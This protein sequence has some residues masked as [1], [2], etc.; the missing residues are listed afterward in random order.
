MAANRE[1]ALPFNTRQY[2]HL[3]VT[4]R[5]VQ[6]SVMAADDECWTESWRRR[7]SCSDRSL[8][9]D[10]ASP[11]CGVP[12]HGPAD[13]ARSV[14]P[15]APGMIPTATSGWPYVAD[16][17]AMRRSRAHESSAPP[18]HAWPLFAAIETIGNVSS[19]SKRLVGRRATGPA[20]GRL[21]ASIRDCSDQWAMK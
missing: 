1:R 10:A 6:P 3:L 2:M 19:T 4:A 21:K 12:R 9:A 16:S 17:A 8:P 11:G 20:G 13:A 15:P 7:T 14:V 5:R 18:P